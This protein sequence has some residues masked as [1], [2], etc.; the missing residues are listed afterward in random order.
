HDAGPRAAEDPGDLLRDGVE[1]LL[2][3]HTA[4]HEHRHM[5]QCGFLG[6]EDRLPHRRR[7]VRRAAQAAWLSTSP[8][9]C[10]ITLRAC[11]RIDGSASCIAQRLPLRDRLGKVKLR[12]L[13]VDDSEPFLA[14][15]R[16]L[17]ESQGVEIVATATSG[18]EALDLAT[19]LSPDLAL[20]DIELGEED[21]F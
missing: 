11:W 16:R 20:V 15:A 7:L 10:P 4:G 6:R 9:T 3:R 8:G 1:D 14:S 19:A 18:A 13:I 12:S 21:G 17:L 5:P 2:R